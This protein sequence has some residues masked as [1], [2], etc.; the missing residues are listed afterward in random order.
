M[1]DIFNSIEQKQKRLTYLTQ[2][3]KSKHIGVISRESTGF[4]RINNSDEIK[5]IRM[6]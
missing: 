2:L 5:Q 3:I 6:L 1:P 4:N